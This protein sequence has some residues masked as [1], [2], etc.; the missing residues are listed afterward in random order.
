M[1][2]ISKENKI[3]LI[4][5]AARGFGR[6]WAEAALRRG[7][8]VIAAAQD[9]TALQS[10]VDAYGGSVV[11]LA[12]DVTDR[13]GVFDTVERAHAYFGR[14]DVIVNNASCVQLGAV[15]E[16][17]EAEARAQFETNAFGALWIIQAAL[18]FLRE[19]G[20][21]HILS[22]SGIGG[23]IGSPLCGIYQA[24]RWALEAMHEALAREVAEFGVKVTLIEPGS[25]VPDRA[26][27]S[28]SHTTPNPAY[29]AVRARVAGATPGIEPSDPH[30]AA[31]AVLR[32]V[33]AEA[34]PLR[35]FLGATLLGIARHAYAE[36]PIRVGANTGR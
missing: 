1:R 13:V 22:V 36:H 35:L 4:T 32:V 24:S 23:I 15:E 14:L 29:D 7:D 12:L 21:G 10:L 11:P 8:W 25:C 28:V 20:R 31:E 33:D 18:P 6:A 17:S 27:S 5:D 26:G 2:M 16:V 34:P 9:V 30:A 3:W 19:Q